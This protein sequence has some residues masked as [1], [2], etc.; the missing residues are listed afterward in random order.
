MEDILGMIS[1]TTAAS[2]LLILA[3]I[4]LIILIIKRQHEFI[5]RAMVIMLLL[6]LALIFLR[7]HEAGRMTWYDIKEKIFAEKQPEYR[8]TVH[9]RN[10]R[11]VRETEYVFHEPRPRLSVRLD[12]NGTYFD[13]VDL[14]PIN[15]VLKHLDLPEV[16][17]KV[18]ELASITGSKSDV[19]QYMWTDYPR[20]TL[21]VERTL[22]Q[23]QI[24]PEV[25]HCLSSI[26]L[27]QK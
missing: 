19:N 23:S 22:C 3:A 7:Q 9:K 21:I 4:W 1:L 27:L 6:L 10:L 26:R 17:E 18:P 8:F 16:K 12:S 15:A 24:S 25:Y 5:F 14:K 2:I 11:D 20:G 13:I